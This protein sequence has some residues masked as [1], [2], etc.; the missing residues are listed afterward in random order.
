MVHKSCILFLIIWL[1]IPFAN[2]QSGML[3]STFGDQGIVITDIDRHDYISAMAI[4]SDQKILVAGY[5]GGITGIGGYHDMTVVRY[6]PDGSFD[7]EFGVSGF[8]HIHP[9]SDYFFYQCDALALQPDG[10]IVLLGK[11]TY[12]KETTELEDDIVLVRLKLNGSIDSTFGSGGIVVTDFGYNTD[13]GYSVLVQ[14]DGRIIATG[15]GPIGYG[16]K[17]ARYE[18]DGE[19]DTD[20]GDEG[21][22]TTFIQGSSTPYTGVIQP[23]GKI[24]LAGVARTGF[25]GDFAMVRYLENGGLDSL[26]GSDGIVQTDLGGMNSYDF[27]LTISLDPDGKIVLGGAVDVKFVPSVSHIGVVRYNSNGSLD[28]SFGNNGI[29]ELSLGEFSLV[30]SIARQPDGKYLLAGSSN[31][32]DSNSNWLLARLEYHGDLDLGFGNKGI[33]TTDLKGIQESAISVLIQSDNRILVGGFN[34]GDYS[35]SQDFVVARYIANYISGTNKIDSFPISI[36][37]NPCTDFITINVGDE[38][39]AYHCKIYD[40]TGRLIR[41]EILYLNS[42]NNQVIDTRLLNTGFYLMEITNNKKRGGTSFIVE[43]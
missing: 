35:D 20:F 8:V 32:I 18:S 33:I 24:I 31:G 43:K 16:F 10:G 42:G 21:F 37:P 15:Q 23:D 26:F 27:A 19:I 29:Y 6:L 2:C 4:Q 9:G 17:M 34:N 5:T 28:K 30:R 14:E 7:Q 12:E 40:L 3:D 39:G 38:S 41:K 1:F 22:V 11:V 13:Q 36:S 25:P